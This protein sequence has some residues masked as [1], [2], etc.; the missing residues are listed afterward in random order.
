M[1]TTIKEVVEYFERQARII[2]TSKSTSKQDKRLMVDIIT[3]IIK[4]ARLLDTVTQS[5]DAN[6]QPVSSPKRGRPRKTITKEDAAAIMG[7][8]QRR[9]Q[10]DKVFES[11]DSSQ[12]IKK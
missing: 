4:N 9:L 6:S 7:R 8:V 10:A 2:N 1:N 5:E 3:G 12:Y 11:I